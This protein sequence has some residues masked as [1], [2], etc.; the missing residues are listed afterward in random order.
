[1][2]NI[3]IWN[4]MKTPIKLQIFSQ[5]TDP[6]GHGDFS[7]AQVRN[8]ATSD[9]YILQPKA[10]TAIDSTFWNSWTQQNATSTLLLNNIISSSLGGLRCTK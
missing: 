2:A 7:T 10:A 1:M 5:I 4:S 9:G 8:L 3:N 6:G